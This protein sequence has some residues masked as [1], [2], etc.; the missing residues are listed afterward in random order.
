MKSNNA[1]RV[2]MLVSSYLQAE[3]SSHQYVVANK[4]ISD[5]HIEEVR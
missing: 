5:F 4:N 2:S 3:C 1:S